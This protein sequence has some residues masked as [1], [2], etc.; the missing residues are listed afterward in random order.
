MSH[1]DSSS[2][3]RSTPRRP[4]RAR[5]YTVAHRREVLVGFFSQWPGNDRHPLGLGRALEDF[6][7]WAIR[8]GRLGDGAASPWWSTVNG[9][10]VDDLA[11][12]HSGAVGPWQDYVDSPPK[13]RQSRLWL[14]HQ[15]SINRG[16]AAA[17]DLLVRESH[18][19]RAFIELALGVVETAAAVDFDTSSGSLGRRTTQIYP[20]C[21]PCG[22]ADLERLRRELGL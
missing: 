22:E 7:D 12:A 1:H 14:A 4:V 5:R 15:D 13:E 21:Y 18:L 16:V 9:V 19:E 6:Q 10:L 8:S 11:E 3:P 17:E 2:Q 20:Q